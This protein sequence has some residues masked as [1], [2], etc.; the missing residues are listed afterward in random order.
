MHVPGPATWCAVRV[1][2][3]WHDRSPRQAAQ[4]A[5]R[6]VCRPGV[7]P[8]DSV[9]TP[10]PTMTCTARPR[11]SPVVEAAMP[12]QVTGKPG[13]C[14]GTSEAASRCIAT[15]GI[16][17]ADVVDQRPSVLRR[18]RSSAK[19]GIASPPSGS[20]MPWVSHQNISP[21]VV[22][23]HMRQRQV[24]WLDVAGRRRPVRCPR[25][26]ARGRRRSSART[27]PG[28]GRWTWR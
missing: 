1:V 28:H 22:R 14:T 21:S 8:A 26:P 25:P 5:S 20:S 18:Q 12:S 11:R 19:P 7:E 15:A 27:A 24:G 9:T 2:S 3:C 6:S 16:V 17:R 10:S 4:S 13:A 23:Q